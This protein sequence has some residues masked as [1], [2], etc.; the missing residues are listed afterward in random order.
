[1]GYNGEGRT[2][3]HNHEGKYGYK[4]YMDCAIT[5]G[6]LYLDS[7]QE[8]AYKGHEEHLI[9]EDTL[10]LDNK[11]HFVL[12]LHLPTTQQTLQNKRYNNVLRQCNK[13]KDY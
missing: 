7:L 11:A 10:T 13:T 12:F 1:M 9:Q 3:Y 5:Q 4:G 6:D 8:L 2:R